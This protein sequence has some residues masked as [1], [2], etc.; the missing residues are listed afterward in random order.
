MPAVQQV[1][2]HRT[3]AKICGD[4][5]YSMGF[6]WL[7]YNLQGQRRP[8]SSLPLNIGSRKDQNVPVVI[9]VWN[10]SDGRIRLRD[11]VV[12]SS[13]VSWLLSG[14]GVPVHKIRALAFLIESK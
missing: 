8:R 11:A 3:N 5:L 6:S 14:L 4:G 1:R 7:R 12:D 10:K 2:E 9:Q 13:V